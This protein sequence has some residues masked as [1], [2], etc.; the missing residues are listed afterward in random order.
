MSIIDIP[1][2]CRQTTEHPLCA[3]L[4]CLPFVGNCQQKVLGI[5]SALCP[6]MVGGWFKPGV[7]GGGGGRLGSN[8]A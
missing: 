7:G 2:Y 5:L 4:V 8:Y 3:S 1:M 6:A